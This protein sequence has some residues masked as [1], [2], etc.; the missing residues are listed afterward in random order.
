MRPETSSEYIPPVTGEWMGSSI[1]IHNVPEI[2]REAENGRIRIYDKADFPYPIQSINIDAQMNEVEDGRGLVLTSTIELANKNINQSWINERF[3]NYLGEA[4]LTET[5]FRL[6]GPFMVMKSIWGSCFYLND[7]ETGNKFL[8]RARGPKGDII[9]SNAADLGNDRGQIIL[10]PPNVNKIEPQSQLLS[11]TK[12]TALLADFANAFY[13]TTQA[14]NPNVAAGVPLQR[15]YQ[16]GIERVAL[17]RQ[18]MIKSLGTA[19]FKGMHEFGGVVSEKPE[20]IQLEDIGGLEEPKRIIRQIA[21]SF[22]HPEV[23]AKWGAEKPQGVLFHGPSGTGKTM[24]ANALASEIDADI[25]SIQSSDVYIKWLGESQRKIKEIFSEAR[26]TTTPL[27]VFFDEFESIVGIT[28]TPG[29]GGADSERNGVAGIFK[30]EMNNLFRENPNV[31]LVAAT[32]N[33][34]MINP[35]LIRSGRFNYKIYIPMPDAQ[36]RSEIFRSNVKPSLQQVDAHHTFKRYETEIDFAALGNLSEGMNGADI[37]EVFRRILLSK[38][39]EEIETGGA[40]HSVT[41]SDIEDEII[42]FQTS[43]P[44]D[45][46]PG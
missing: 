46:L 42:R 39:M 10:N 25:T 21:N 19:A 37:K 36:T 6:R 16:V 7:Q 15:D 38:A 4:P 23:I 28:V 43:R 9:I 27:V 34:E 33:I 35:S 11:I 41:Q 13:S 5:T 44:G 12:A 29:M 24:L 20:K 30:Q 32:N 45:F 14:D 31:L 17:T 8:I 40:I 22:K 3:N 1:H 2:V 18:S 26:K